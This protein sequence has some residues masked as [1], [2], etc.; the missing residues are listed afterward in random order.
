MPLRNAS[1]PPRATY[2][3]Q[4]HHG[5]RFG[6]LHAML[7]YLKS[8]GI[9][10]LYLSPIFTAAPGSLHGYDVCDYRSINKELGGRQGFELLAKEARAQGFGIILDFVPNHMGIA[11]PLNAWWRDVLE[12]G[13]Q[14]SYA[15]FFDIQWRVTTSEGRP[16]VLIPM[17]EDHYGKV[18]EQGKIS[19]GYD[20]EFSVHHQGVALPMNPHSYAALLD[21]LSR[22]LSVGEDDREALQP[23]V[24]EL[25]TDFKV[26]PSDCAAKRAYAARINDAKEKLRHVFEQR[27]NLKL[28]LEE[29]LKALNGVPGDPSSFAALNAILEEQHYRLARWQTGAHEINYRRFFAIDSLVGLRME[30]EEVFEAAH[31]LLQELIRAGWVTGMR[32]DHVDGLREPEKYLRG[33][34]T[35]TGGTPE[36]PF[37][38]AVEKILAGRETLPPRWPAHGATGYEFILQV[39]GLLVDGASEARFDQ[40]LSQFVGESQEWTTMVYAKKKMIISVLFANAVNTLGVELTQI[41]NGDWRWR[42]LTR[43]ELTTAVSETMACLGVYRTYREGGRVCAQDQARLEEACELAIGRNPLADPKPFQFLRDL[44]IGDY[45]PPGLSADYEQALA[46]W[47][48][49]FQQYTGAVMAKSVEDTA[50]YTFCRLIALNEVGGDPGQFGCPVA[51]FHEI[52][53]NRLDLTPL[54]LLTTSTHDTKLSEDVRARLYG[55]SEIPHEWENWI[56]EWHRLNAVHLSETKDR[57]LAPDALDEYRFYQVLLGAWPLRPETIDDEFRQRLRQH[58]RKAVDEAKRHTSALHPNEDYYKACDLFVDRLMFSET[59]PQ[60]LTSLAAAA[61]RVARLG[62][63]NS[64]SQLVLKCTVPGI[65]DFYQGNESWDF[66]LV[67][68]DNRRPVDFAHLQE[69]RHRAD[70]QAASELFAEWENGAIKVKVTQTLLGYR[71][72]HPHLFAAGDYRPVGIQGEFADRVVAFFRIAG[73]QKLLVVVPRTAAQLGSPPLGLVWGDTRLEMKDEGDGGR[74][75]FTNR[76]FT[77]AGDLPVRSLF[78]ELPFAVLEYLAPHEN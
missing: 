64:L 67:D 70:N 3:V 21:S 66:S 75:I 73:H 78:S 36:N 43:H 32:I 74:D 4:L 20:G 72:L 54:S 35:L 7:P 40:I 8:L 62:M 51:A 59:A 29:R 19:V 41:V 68:P 10:D 23:V 16:R 15:D 71:A 22:D 12:N 69:L 63:L 58:F 50:Y 9:S 45:P 6:H 38:V 48:A 5:F 44:L 39:A 46:E 60:F 33:L 37:Y 1:H 30:R 57:T 13:R 49:T 26:A 25:G 53:R 18:L 61:R 14:S 55:L 76:H 52:N 47:V 24:K 56:A 11:G 28:K 2:R 17:L 65:P 34:Q 77:H 31:P 42:D 27:L